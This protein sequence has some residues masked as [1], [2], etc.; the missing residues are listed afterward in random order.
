MSPSENCILVVSGEPSGD[1]H[2]GHLIQALSKELPSLRA[3]GMGGMA[4]RNA[5]A[6]ILQDFGPLSVV[7]FGGVPRVLPLLRQVKRNLLEQ[8]KNR[9]PR[10]I[11]LVDYPGFNLSFAKAIKKL[12]DPPKIIYFIPPQ[13]WAWA[14]GRARTIARIFDLVLTIYPFEPSY[15]TSHGGRAEF[16]GNPVAYGLRNC[17][18][19]E[20]ARSRLNIPDNAKVVSFL[21]G[22]RQREIER[23]VPPL[24]ETIQILKNRWPNLVCLI[25]EADAIKEGEVR[26]ALVSPNDS[27]RIIRGRQ[28][29]VIRAAD[30]AAVVSGTATL[31]TAILGTPLIVLY[32]TDWLTFFLVKYFLLQVDYVS[33]ANLLAGKEVAPEL[34][35]GRDLGKRVAEGI[36]LLLQDPGARQRQ[37]LEFKKVQRLLDGPNPYERAAEQIRQ[38]LELER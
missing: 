19:K 5:G 9:R 15:F 27:I 1:L 4:M 18:S 26:K 3:F 30:A 16:I 6:E 20:E 32:I 36:T 37:T 29:E 24:E 17:P 7:G 34:Q 35:Q 33:L 10:A 23:H 31:E 11:I 28:H 8:T 2:A 38:M 12:P 22:S 13:V 25:S 14:S 21:P